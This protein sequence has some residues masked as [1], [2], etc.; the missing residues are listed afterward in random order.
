MNNNILSICSFFL[1]GKAKALWTCTTP[2]ADVYEAN[3]FL[4]TAQCYTQCVAQR[5]QTP[6]ETWKSFDHILFDSYLH[7][8]QRSFFVWSNE[9]QYDKRLSAILC[10]KP[11]LDT[12]LLNC[13][14][15]QRIQYVRQFIA[16][17]EQI[18][19]LSEGDRQR[20]EEKFSV[21]TDCVG[22]RLK[23]SHNK[24]ILS[25]LFNQFPTGS[26]SIV[27]ESALAS[28]EAF[29]ACQKHCALL[30]CA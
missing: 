14:F 11:I 22:L 13:T 30:P 7:K 4:S 15:S 9:Y 3:I 20:F 12:L 19:L 16:L 27:T 6:L 28:Q 29:R 25:L 10:Q 8:M 5:L 1:F 23:T 18:A 21:K 26:F 17:H 2:S 24:K